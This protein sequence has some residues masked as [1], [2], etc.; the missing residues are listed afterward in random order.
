MHRLVIFRSTVGVT[1][2][3]LEDA[4]SQM[5]KYASQRFVHALVRQQ[6]CHCHYTALLSQWER[7][8]DD[9]VLVNQRNCHYDYASL[10]SQWDRHY[11][12][13]RTVNRTRW[14]FF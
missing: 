12:D 6:D 4:A 9:T 13:N 1:T 5:E 11:D 14:L 10:M 3:Q 2:T 7:H 8:R